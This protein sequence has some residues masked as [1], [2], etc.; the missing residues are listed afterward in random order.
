MELQSE[1]VKEA[2]QKTRISE[3]NADLTKASYT[4]FEGVIGKKIYVT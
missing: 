3:L 1:Y 4:P 2:Y